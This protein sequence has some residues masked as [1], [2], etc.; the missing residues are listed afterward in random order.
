MDSENPPE[1]GKWLKRAIGAVYFIAVVILIPFF[2]WPL[3]NST[4]T[5]NPKM[6]AMVISTVFLVL[7]LPISIYSVASHLV[8]FNQP[9]LQRPICRVLLMVPVYS[10]TSFLS[11]QF[12]QFSLY[13]DTLRE[14]YEA[15]AL[16]NFMALVLR[17]LLRNYDL[18]YVLEYKPHQPHI[19]PF[20]CL[21]PFPAGLPFIASCKSGVVQ[22]CFVRTLTTLVALVTQLTDRYHEGEFDFRFA[23]LYLVVV[24]NISQV[25]A[26]YCLILLYYTMRVELRP[27]SPMLKF[28]AI[29]IL[30]FLTFWQSVLLALLVWTKVLTPNDAWAWKTPRELSNG[31][32]AF[33]IIIEMF[34][35][36]LMHHH[37]FPVAPFIAG[38]F[39]QFGTASWSQQIRSLWD[40]SDITEDVREHVRV[41]GGVVQDARGRL[42][43]LLHQSWPPGNEEQSSEHDDADD[44]PLITA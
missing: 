34:A 13:F 16:Y 24:N 33:V 31:L 29:K 15:Y 27:L 12:T 9:E 40:H 26:M 43:H 37:A 19:F 8:N 6:E 23:Y 39:N 20:C 14:W 1:N 5:Q 18:R 32:Q 10:L 3:V 28:A 22:Y 41:I 7:T 21:V 42:G 30:V 36:S 44:Q 11:L 25:W 17:F 4:S 35:L 2:I 38:G